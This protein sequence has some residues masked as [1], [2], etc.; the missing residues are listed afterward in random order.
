MSENEKLG[1]TARAREIIYEA[2]GPE[3]EWSP[4]DHRLLD[5]AQVADG[6]LV[7]AADALTAA[8]ARIKVLSEA[9]A[10][11]AC[12]ADNC[13]CVQGEEQSDRVACGFKARQALKGA[14]DEG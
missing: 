2:A 4:Y 5:L 6:D 8:E 13:D 12:D 1:F 11:Y 3:S 10:F 14:S 9:L 7:D